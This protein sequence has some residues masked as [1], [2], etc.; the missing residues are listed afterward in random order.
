[1]TVGRG[2]GVLEDLNGISSSHILD[3]LTKVKLTDIINLPAPTQGA[4]QAPKPSASSP[5]RTAAGG[6]SPLGNGHAVHPGAQAARQGWDDSLLPGADDEDG[7]AAP[8]GPPPG[9]TRSVPFQPTAL[10]STLDTSPELGHTM[11]RTD[12]VTSA[13]ESDDFQDAMEEL[14]SDGSFFMCAS[15]A[16]APRAAVVRDTWT[17]AGGDRQ[18]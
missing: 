11:R 15:P 2:A 14:V 5:S 6:L 17:S 7:E 1:M 13:E 3:L 16:A 10:Q 12:S 9:G 8:G 4:P 18:G